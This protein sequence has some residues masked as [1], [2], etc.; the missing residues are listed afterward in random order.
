MSIPHTLGNC[1]H[2]TELYA[3]ENHIEEIPV[4]LENMAMLTTLQLQHNKIKRIPLEL[5]S[6]L[7]LTQVDFTFNPDLENLPDDD[8][9]R[10]DAKQVL[11]HLAQQR[12][13]KEQVDKLLQE[14][15]ALCQEVE[16]RELRIQELES[17]V[18]EVTKE[19]EDLNAS[20]PRT[21]MKVKVV[22]IKSTNTVKNKITADGSRICVIQ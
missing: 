14:K 2:L 15:D 18:S 16:G 9:T 20:Y 11:W 6:C 3:S 5:A 13:H 19:F 1:R 22:V 4:T 8:Y 7:C 21:Y 12:N 17:K 10:R